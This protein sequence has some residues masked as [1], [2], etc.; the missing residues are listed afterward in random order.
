M[1]TRQPHAVSS[2]IGGGLSRVLV[3]EDHAQ[4]RE[5]ISS[6]L[7]NTGQWR[8]VAAVSDGAE[9]VRKAHELSPDFIL[10]DIGLPTLNGIQAARQ[11]LAQCPRSRILFVS[12]HQSADIA[13]AALE[14]GAQG[15]LIKSEIHRELLPAMNAILDGRRFVS[16]RLAEHVVGAT[17]NEP[18]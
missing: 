8:V 16:E 12:G 5:H 17:G 6:I 9:A 4:W 14:T 13:E 2:D 10:L 1:Q 3:V 11:I 15:F 7:E 18:L